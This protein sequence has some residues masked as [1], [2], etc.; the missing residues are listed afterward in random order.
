MDAL[1]PDLD[2]G[3]ALAGAAHQGTACIPGAL[4][5]RFRRSL[6]QEIDAGPS[7]SM[8]G[9][10]GITPHTEGKW[11]RRLVAVVTV[12]GWARF[13]ITRD[14]Q[15]SVVREWRPGLGDLVLMRGPGLAGARD[16]RP[17]HLAEG[18]TRGERCS[19]G[20]RMAVGGPP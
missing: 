10:L 2:L 8:T 3:R 7:R 4:D 11:Y 9:S 20:V 1:A 17:F 6:R 5:E 16:G 13:A 19:L 14:R 15:G 18:P 12:Y